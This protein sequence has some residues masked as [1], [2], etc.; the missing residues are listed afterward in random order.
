MTDAFARLLVVL[1]L[2]A[3]IYGVIRLVEWL[4]VCH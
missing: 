1:G 3:A 2:F 4:L